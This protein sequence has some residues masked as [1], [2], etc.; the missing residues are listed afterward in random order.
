VRRSLPIFLSSLAVSWAVA[1]ALAGP[2]AG[3]DFSTIIET[4]STPLENRVRTV[5]LEQDLTPRSYRIALR[6]HT[7]VD[8]NYAEVVARRSAESFESR[9]RRSVET[10]RALYALHDSL[11]R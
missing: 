6:R 10:R 8:D 3:Q 7:R 5:I 9:Y 11:S 4:E 1:W 2:A